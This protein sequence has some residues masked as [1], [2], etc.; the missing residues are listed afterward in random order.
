MAAPQ[1]APYSR[2]H[3]TAFL[4]SFSVPK[5]AAFPETSL[6]C[7]LRK[8]LHLPKDSAPPRRVSVQQG[9]NILMRGRRKDPHPDLSV[10]E[11][12]F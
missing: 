4:V 3:G 9:I 12:S 6:E 1:L 7:F 5:L 11:N 10:A 8:S 2:L